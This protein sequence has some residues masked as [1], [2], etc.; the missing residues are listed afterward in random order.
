MHA[1]HTVFFKQ[2]KKF[3]S[4]VT[5]EKERLLL[6]SSG[7]GIV[8]YLQDACLLYATSGFHV[9]RMPAWEATADELADA[10]M[11]EKDMEMW[12]AALEII[13]EGLAPTP[14]VLYYFYGTLAD[15][16]CHDG[17]QALLADR[18]FLTDGFLLHSICMRRGGAASLRR[19]IADACGMGQL[20]TE[21]ARVRKTLVLSF[22]TLVQY[23]VELHSWMLLASVFPI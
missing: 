18:D 14:E 11:S 21:V 6:A 19:S 9:L 17:V 20:L 22:R 2:A 8:K 23:E 15:K 4:L 12:R 13:C 10:R 16:V 3:A 1:L 7:T 5:A